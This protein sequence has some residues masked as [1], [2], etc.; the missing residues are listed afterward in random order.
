MVV[1]SSRLKLTHLLHQSAGT[2]A[3]GGHEVTALVLFD[4]IL[5]AD[6]L[7]LRCKPYQ[8]ADHVC[9]YGCVGVGAKHHEAA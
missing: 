7:P 2:A 5:F 3:T 8:G 1:N 9:K 6:E 4:A